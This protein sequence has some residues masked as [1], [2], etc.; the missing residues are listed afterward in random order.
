MYMALEYDLEIIP[1]INKI[2]LPSADIEMVKHQID[3]ELGLDPDMAI[4]VSAKTGKGVDDLFKA[5]VDY[6]PEPAG[7][8]SDPLKALILI[9]IMIPTGGLL[10]MS[11]FLMVSSRRDR[12]LNSG[13][14]ML[15][16]KLRKRGSFV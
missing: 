4:L 11:G 15:N 14:T 5:I 6:I 3:H 2:D 1:V 9:R 13:L 10:F 8:K 16:I 12:L 7:L